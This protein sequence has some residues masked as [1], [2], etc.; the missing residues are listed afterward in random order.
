MSLKY[1]PASVPQVL[2]SLHHPHVVA[3]IG[4]TLDAA[5]DPVDASHSRADSI[6]FQAGGGGMRCQW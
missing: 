6:G 1:E 5:G 4:V 2:S 3:A